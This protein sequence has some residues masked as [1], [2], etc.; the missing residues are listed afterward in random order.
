M[1]GYNCY[2]NIT[3]WQIS[4]KSGIIC[5]CFSY[6]AR[7]TMN[8]SITQAGT[9]THRILFEVLVS[10]FYVVRISI[11]AL[12]L[13]PSCLLIYIAPDEKSTSYP[14]GDSL[15]YIAL[16]YGSYLSPRQN[17]HAGDHE[18]LLIWVLQKSQG[19]FQNSSRDAQMI[20]FF[21]FFSLFLAL[22]PPSSV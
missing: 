8:S 15:S 2:Y 17:F 3:G 19:E 1:T 6:H 14:P 10:T 18:S 5:F 12:I 4:W 13:R 9:G 20:S 21:S 11:S 16:L 22:Y 7:F